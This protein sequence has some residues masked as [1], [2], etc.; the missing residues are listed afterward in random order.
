MGLLVDNDLFMG[1]SIMTVAADHDVVI[2]GS[3]P[4]GL[5]AAIHAVRRKVGV[6]VLG[7]E[8]K[9]SDT[10]DSGGSKPS[11]GAAKT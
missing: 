5:Q 3:G 10:S 1:G 8:A 4:A 2:L 6:L 9:S 7:K 11:S